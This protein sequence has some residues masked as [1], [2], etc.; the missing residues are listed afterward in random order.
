VSPLDCLDQTIGNDLF[1]AALAEH[2]ANGDLL[3][4]RA[5][6][7]LHPTSLRWWLRQPGRPDPIDYAAID[8][9]R[10]GSVLDIGCATGRHVEALTR[11]GIAAEGIDINPAAVGIARARLRRAPGRR[12]EL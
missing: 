1:A 5:G 9:L 2:G 10:A 8:L 6:G 11:R 12:V 3:V 4:E 7:G